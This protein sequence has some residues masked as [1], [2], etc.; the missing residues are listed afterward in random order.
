MSAEHFD[1]KDYA[2]NMAEQAS[3]LLPADLNDDDRQ[4]IKDTLYNYMLLSGEAL[5]TDKSTNFSEEDGQFICQVIAEWI[6]HKGVDLANSDIPGEYWDAIMHKIAYTIYETLK[7]GIKRNIP[8]ED[9]L[10]NV[11]DNVNKVWEK[12]IDELAE[13]DTLSSDCAEKAKNLSNI[14]KMAEEAENEKIDLLERIY[15]ADSADKKSLKRKFDIKQRFETVKEKCSE[16]SEALITYIKGFIFI[17]AGFCVAEFLYHFMDE[18][19]ILSII[20][21]KKSFMYILFVLSMI[22][23][24]AF[25]WYKSNQKAVKDE[26]KKLQKIRNQLEGLSNPDNMYDKLGVETVRIK[27]GKGLLPLADMNIPDSLLTKIVTVRKELTDE[28]GYII[29]NIRIIDT[30]ELDGNEYVFE[31]RNNQV[32]SGYVYPGKY[33]VIADQWDSVRREIPDDAIIGV[34]PTYQ[35]QAYWIPQVDARTA[36]KVVCVDAA[37]VIKTHLKVELIN[38]VEDILT[39]ADVQKLID[40]VDRQEPKLY[41]DIKENGVTEYDLQKIFTCLIREKVSIK[42][43][44]FIFERLCDYSRYSQEPYIL[45]ERIRAALGRKICLDN[46]DED[47][48]L[49][50]LTLSPEWEKTLD[51]SVQSTELGTM[52]LLE[53]MQ[54]QELIESTVTTLMY[55]HRQIGQQPV[56][57]CSPRIR[58]PLYQLLV[59]HI[60]TIVVLSFSELI[61]DIKVEAVDAIK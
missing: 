22:G 32:A 51:E 14:D 5:C 56:I 58:L 3:E 35:T 41:K 28:L 48:V 33:M 20:A 16:K 1:Y 47:H 60:P 13:A 39:I 50:S 38:H 17:T 12:S 31:V 11:E 18:I 9:L 54:V 43:I 45:S 26:L 55:A 8:Q 27:I 19:N 25:A 24:A 10:V 6:F 42:D 21:E 52:F 29:P 49:Y 37:D 59:R 30:E 57:L 40:F 44:V 23:I 7:T 34:D 61:T 46:V 36:K 2:N 15:K 53:P 4:Y